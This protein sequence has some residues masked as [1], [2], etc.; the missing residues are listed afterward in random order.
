MSAMAPSFVRDCS[1]CK[2]RQTEKKKKSGAHKKVILVHIMNVAPAWPEGQPSFV[3]NG[4][5][6]TVS[7]MRRMQNRLQSKY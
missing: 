6:S 7:Q 4:Q 1:I 2:R 5:E 3:Y